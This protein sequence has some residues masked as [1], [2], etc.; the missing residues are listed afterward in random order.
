MV[1]ADPDV[2]H[3]L[4][5]IVQELREAG[6][7]VEGQRVLAVIGRKDPDLG[8]SLVFRAPQPPVLRIQI[9]EQVVV[10]DQARRS[11]GAAGREPQDRVAAVRMAIHEL[12]LRLC[13]T[14]PAARRHPKMSQRIGRDGI[15]APLELTPGDGPI[16]IRIQP[17]RIV[18]VAQRDVPLPG[19][20]LVPHRE[21]EVAVARFVGHGGRAPEPRDQ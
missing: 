18:E 7:G 1:V 19:H 20:D 9:E 3:P 14:G 15:M 12:L 4:S 8:L 5:A 10:Q 21:C 13:G 17:D 11:S 6:G 16:A 2:P